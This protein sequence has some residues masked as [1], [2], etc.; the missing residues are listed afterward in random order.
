M[1][2]VSSCG[3]FHCSTDLSF[4]P[5]RNTFCPQAMKKIIIIV[6][7]PGTSSTFS[8]LFCVSRWKCSG[9][10]RK[11]WG[12]RFTYV[13]CIISLSA[14]FLTTHRVQQPAVQSCCKRE[15]TFNVLCREIITSSSAAFRQESS[16]NHYYYICSI[17]SNICTVSMKLWLFLPASCEMD[18]SS[19]ACVYSFKSSFII[20]LRAEI[21]NQLVDWHKSTQHQS[22]ESI[23][24]FILEEKWHKFTGNLL[25]ILVFY[26]SKLNIFG[27]RIFVWL[28]KIFKDITKGSVNLKLAFL[29]FAG[30]S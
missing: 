13:M 23:N 16:I 8:W 14:V 6:Q 2:H 9:S 19:L 22:C 1:L 4:N 28:N 27:F 21:N 18:L 15:N 3:A 24:R 26:Y 17:K 12:S 7:L 25:K 20:V 30:I 29:I 11:L 5:L 10:G